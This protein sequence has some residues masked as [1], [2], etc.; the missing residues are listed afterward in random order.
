[1]SDY[2]DPND[3]MWR[4]TGYEPAAGNTG[5]IWGWIAGAVFLAVVLLIVFSAQREPTRT[6]SNDVTPPASTRM[7]PHTGLN[8]I[9]PTN[10]ATPAPVPAP[11]GTD[12]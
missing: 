1:M 5:S 3:P 2:R 7:A 4:D 12:Q 6:A 8:P 9:S 11:K 10:P